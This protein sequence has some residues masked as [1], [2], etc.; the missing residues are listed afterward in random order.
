MNINYLAKQMGHKNI[1]M[2]AAIYDK[3]LDEANKKESARVWE[4]L[5]KVG[6]LR[7]TR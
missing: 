2:I 4:E 3:W 5:K 6:S 7:A 1:N